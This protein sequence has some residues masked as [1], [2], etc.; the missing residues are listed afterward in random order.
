MAAGF[1]KQGNP[2][3]DKVP[4]HPQGSPKSVR[5]RGRKA[6]NIFEYVSGRRGRSELKGFYCI[7]CCHLWGV[8]KNYSISFPKGTCEEIG[9]CLLWSSLTAHSTAKIRKELEAEGASGL[10]TS[11]LVILVQNSSEECA[12]SQFLQNGR[13][14]I[15]SR[16]IIKSILNKCKK[17]PNKYLIT[18]NI[19]YS[20]L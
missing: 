15:M 17:T 4:S 1:R 19:F 13:V 16:N 10:I 18:C 9:S 7:G 14:S 12:C 6:L 11:F 2:P 20:V 8:S 3:E 5:V